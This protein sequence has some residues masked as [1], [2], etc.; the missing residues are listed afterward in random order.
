MRR[1]STEVPHV[2]GT[3]VAS[4]V[5]AANRPTRTSADCADC[6]DCAG[7]AG[8]ACPVLRCARRLCDAGRW[9]IDDAEACRYLRSVWK[10]LGATGSDWASRR[11]PDRS[12]LSNVQGTGRKS[13]SDVTLPVTCGCATRLVEGRVAWSI[14]C[15]APVATRPAGFA[16]RVCAVGFATRQPLG[17]V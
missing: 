9:T 16:K 10:R 14:P 13:R 11:G 6:A 8:K 15:A 4:V 5:D 17:E 7:R 2:A 1:P 12:P 3:L